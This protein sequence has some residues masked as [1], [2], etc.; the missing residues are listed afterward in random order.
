MSVNVCRD[1]ARASN[2][3]GRCQLAPGLNPNR[4][5]AAS[6]NGFFTR[7]RRVPVSRRPH[8]LS[9][10]SNGKLSTGPPERALG[11]ARVFRGDLFL[12]CG[13]DQQECD[14]VSQLVGP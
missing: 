13:C 14:Q 6:P 11:V 1:R 7:W 2:P 5:A 12:G 8:V 9:S 4:L 3:V 10:P